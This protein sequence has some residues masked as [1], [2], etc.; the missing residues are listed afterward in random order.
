MDD[1][2]RNLKSPKVDNKR[3]Y[4]MED[5][6]PVNREEL[7]V[8]SPLPADFYA[9]LSDQNFV[10]VGRRGSPQVQELHAVREN[11]FEQLFVLRDQFKDCVGAN[12]QI[13]E[14]AIGR[15][16]ISD[17]K[18][19]DYLFLAGD[20]V[21]KEI[22]A[23][24]F[25]HESLVHAQAVANSIIALV[26]AKEDLDHIV[27]ALGATSDELM[28]HSLAVSAISVVIGRAMNWTVSTNL[29]KL[30]LAGLLHDI[31]L[32]EIAPE[33]LKK[34]RHQM[35]TAE[36][37]EYETHVHRGVCILQ[38]MPSVP[39]EVVAVAMEHHENAIGQGY[40][41]HLRD[42]KMNPFS[43]IVALADAFC[44]FTFP[45]VNNPKPR[46]PEEV[47]KYIGLTLGQPFS[48][49]AYQALRKTLQAEVKKKAA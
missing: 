7:I 17:L 34:A 36:V 49:P 37:K 9:R 4:K 44:E 8:F 24:G 21:F 14:V 10:L 47:L 25:N 30:A 45:G 2:A 11:G 27:R 18:K 32:K 23:L 38:S 1:T 48:K 3:L 31:G 13:A 12:L 28:K 6:V 46:S 39:P 19:V 5:F 29:Q 41:K 40:P 35:T 22:S 16:E 33:I 43:R 15:S 26:S 20:S 42:I